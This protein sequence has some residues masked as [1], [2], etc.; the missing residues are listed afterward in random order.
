MDQF[1]R[2]H[3][4]P[5]YLT[6]LEDMTMWV[7]YT[8]AEQ[9]LVAPDHILGYQYPISLL[10]SAVGKAYLAYCPLAERRQLL[11]EIL[12]LKNE[13]DG[14]AYDKT[15]V[16]ALLDEVRHNGY[17][18]TG[19]ILGDRGRGIAVPIRHGRRVLGS[20]SMRHYRSKR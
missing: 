3:K 9:S 16:D 13:Q 7:R 19:S 2:Q 5:L 10:A 1:T 6:T 14:I 18:T 12:G 20:I 4:W 8:T 17:A 11:R 15:T